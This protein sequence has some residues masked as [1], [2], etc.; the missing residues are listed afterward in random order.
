MPT[1][2]EWQVWRQM[3]GPLGIDRI[4]YVPVMPGLDGF[5]V[6]QYETM[7]EALAVVD[8]ELVFLEPIATKTT[9]DIPAGDIVMVLGNTGMDNH[10]HSAEDQRY[11]ITTL[12]ATGHL[13]GFNAAAIA[14]H[15][16]IL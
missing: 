3:K 11:K 13:Y 7:E 8:G 15:E 9:A 16:R 5:N 6:E 1:E 14:L 12:S 4:I 2:V 10:K